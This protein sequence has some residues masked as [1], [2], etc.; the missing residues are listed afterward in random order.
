ME[1]RSKVL[2]LGIG[3]GIG[4]GAGCSQ[5]AP[6]PQLVRACAQYWGRQ[7]SA[8]FGDRGKCVWCELEAA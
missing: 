5:G 6:H 8:R 2:Q 3:I 4:G 1:K 7:P